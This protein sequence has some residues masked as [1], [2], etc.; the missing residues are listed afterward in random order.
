MSNS[1]EQPRTHKTHIHTSP[2]ITGVFWAVV[3]VRDHRLN[4][5]HFACLNCGQVGKLR[6][7]LRP[8]RVSKLATS[9]R[10]FSCHQSRRQARC[11][12]RRSWTASMRTDPCKEASYTAPIQTA[13]AAAAAAANARRKQKQRNPSASASAIKT[14][15]TSTTPVYCTRIRTFKLYMNFVCLLV[16][17]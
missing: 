6:H 1:K 12:R 2:F 14:S 3:R 13:T 4:P 8:R 7:S 11:M 16:Y 9:S 5:L 15:S 10:H 17:L